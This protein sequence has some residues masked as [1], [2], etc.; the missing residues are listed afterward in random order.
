MDIYSA[1][2]SVNTV[3]AVISIALMLAVCGSI[4]PSSF[5]SNADD[6]S[7]SDLPGIYYIDSYSPAFDSDIPTSALITGIKEVGEDS[8]HHVEAY[9]GSNSISLISP[10]LELSP[11][12]EYVLQYVLKDGVKKESTPIQMGALIKSVTNNSPASSAG[13]LPLTYLYSMTNTSVTGS[14]TEYIQN[15]NEFMDYMKTTHA[16]DVVLVTVA[17][18]ADG[19][20]I[21]TVDYE[22]T[23]T[24]SGSQGYLGISVT[25]SGFTFTTPT[26]MLERATTPFAHV[27]NP[28]DFVKS[29][30]SYLSGPVNGLDPIPD[31]ITWWYDT[32]NGDLTWIIV[33]M[34]YWL[35]WL[36][37]LL[38]ISNA[39][40]AYPFD[41]GF[42]FEGGINW[43]LERLGI[44][45]TERRG[46]LSGS[47]SNAI[48]TVTLMMFILVIVGLLI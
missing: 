18:I 30:L 9:I 11:L 24:A 31:S 39:L 44:K 25:E 29:L 37:I 4:T 34:L 40:P 10:D 35:F 15:T 33:K 2:I 28:I 43:L 12:N 16:G 45:D 13:M 6:D 3:V 7:D 41:G 48:S 27:E 20:D 23:L 5:D 47:I 14:E 17:T 8:F 38:A 46:K 32:P 22:I 21:E 26:A 36:D 1:G 42:L 19:G